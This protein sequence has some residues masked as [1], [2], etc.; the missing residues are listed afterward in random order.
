MA[1]NDQQHLVQDGSSSMPEADFSSAGLAPCPLDAV[2]RGR[3]RWLGRVS[4][5]QGGVKDVKV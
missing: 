4:A 5:G 2:Q 1:Y 3:L